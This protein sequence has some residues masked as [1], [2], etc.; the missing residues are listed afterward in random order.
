MKSLPRTL[1]RL[2]SAPGGHTSFVIGPLSLLAPLCLALL[3]GGQLT[4]TIVPRE[5]IRTLFLRRQLVHLTVWDPNPT[6]AEHT[7]AVRRSIIGSRPPSSLAE[8]D[9][10]GSSVVE[11]ARSSVTVASLADDDGGGSG[12]GV[13]AD[14]LNVIALMSWTL[15]HGDD[16]DTQLSEEQRSLKRLSRQR[17]HVHGG[18]KTV[19]IF[20]PS[21]R[22][23]S[24][25]AIC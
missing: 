23:D 19:S 21:S 11:T 8:R 13:T 20:H 15:S 16:V 4:D 6:L 3:N 7:D 17:T 18:R 9:R 1:A 24:V 2:L 5:E 12:S 25:T 10:G 22:Q 14:P